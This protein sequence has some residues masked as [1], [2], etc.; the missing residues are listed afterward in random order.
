METKTLEKILTA[1]ERWKK[2]HKSPIVEKVKDRFNDPFLILVATILSLRT[3]DTVTE[4]VFEKLYSKVKNVDDLEAISENELE[5]LINSVGFHKNKVKTLKE[6]A[7]NLREN[8]NGKVP[9]KL[10][11]L[12]SIKGVGRKTANL[13]LIEGF[14]KYGICVDT[15]VHR[16]LNWWG[17]VSTKSPDNTEGE[18]RKK[19]PKKWWKKINNLLVTFGQ[20]VCT[21]LNPKCGMCPVYK[22]CSYKKKKG[23]NG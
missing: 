22:L 23:L 5:N 3:R 6:I 10:K 8:F 21:P 12:L 4:K 2:E 1:L 15:H 9:E 14:N 11:D 19:L 13:V 7:R 17:Y 18:L 20:N 16:I